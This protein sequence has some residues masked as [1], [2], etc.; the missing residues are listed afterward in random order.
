MAAIIQHEASQKSRQKKQ[1]L[2]IDFTPMVDLGFLLIT[3]FMLTAT[4]QRLNSLNISLP[5]KTKAV[6]PPTP[7]KASRV[8]TV[9]LAGNNQLYYYEN[10]D[11]STMHKTD[12]TKTEIDKALHNKSVAINAAM[13]SIP[14]YEAQYKNRL[15]SI[16]Q[17]Q[18]RINRIASLHENIFVFIKSTNDA[19]Y[20]NLVSIIDKLNTQHIM[21]YAIG[22]MNEEER[23]KVE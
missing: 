5:E 12:F 22:E 4:L 17:M 19:K 10:A 14:V 20:H 21:H 15:I 13:K 8:F 11:C 23:K 3:F 1:S 7:V 2:H 18:Q 16:E 6:A 9:I